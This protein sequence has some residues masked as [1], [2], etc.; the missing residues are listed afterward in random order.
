VGICDGACDVSFVI[1]GLE[2]DV[3]AVAVFVQ[4]FACYFPNGFFGGARLVHFCLHSLV[5]F[6][7]RSLMA[8]WIVL[9]SL[10]RVNFIARRRL[11]MDC[12]LLHFVA[13]R[14]RGDRAI[15]RSGF[16]VYSDSGEGVGKFAERGSVG[17]EP[18]I[19]RVFWCTLIVW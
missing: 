12:S 19:D 17:I 14:Q 16:L 1:K 13:R 4:G 8:L 2:W 6:L 7:V 18:C 5:S 10:L 11:F 3:A 15:H 9:D